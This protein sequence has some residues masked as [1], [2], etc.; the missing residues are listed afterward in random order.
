MPQTGIRTTASNY[1]VDTCLD[2]IAYETG[3]RTLCITYSLQKRKNIILYTAAAVNN[4]R[5]LQL[6]P[7]RMQNPRQQHG[8]IVA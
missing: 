4:L 7:L 5:S 3:Q 8:L 6:A 2:Y 1:T